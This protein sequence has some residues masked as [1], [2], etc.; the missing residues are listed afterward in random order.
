LGVGGLTLRKLRSRVVQRPT[1]F[2][3][4][5]EGKV[6]ASGYPASRKQLE[7]VSKQGVNVVLTLTEYPLPSDWVNGLPLTT[8]HMPMK[9]HEPPTP[10]SLQEA[11][12]VVRDQLSKGK[13]VMVH[14]LAGQGRTMCVLA[15]YLIAEEGIKPDEA[16][17]FLRQKRPG[18]VE[19]RQENSVREFAKRSLGDSDLIQR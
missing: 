9:D 11:V 5:E 7:W 18:A 1:G 13:K 2:L 3:W 10:E 19:K 4:I 6:A 16:I 8:F 17:L 12:V 15:G 14:C